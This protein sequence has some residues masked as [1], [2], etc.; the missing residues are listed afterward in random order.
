MLNYINADEN[1]LVDEILNKENYNV[2]KLEEFIISFISNQNKMNIIKLV[3]NASKNNAAF[4]G[5]VFDRDLLENLKKQIKD[6]DGFD[7]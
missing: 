1:F 7:V 5:E 2:Y 3:Y 4:V 6:Y